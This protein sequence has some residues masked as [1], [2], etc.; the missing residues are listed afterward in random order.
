[1]MPQIS[2]ERLTMA[3][4]VI[5]REVAARLAR[6]P[7]QAATEQRLWWELSSCLLSSQVPYPLAVAAAD[8]IDGQGLLLAPGGGVETLASG[9]AA[10]LRGKLLVNGRPRAYRFAATRASQLAKTRFKVTEAAGG[11]SELLAGFSHPSEARAWLVRNAPGI[12]PKQA[13]MFLRNCGASYD[14]AIL[15]RHVMWYMSMVRLLPGPGRGIGSLSGYDLHEERL[16]SHA[17]EI[18]HAVGLLDWAIWIVVRAAR[19][20]DQRPRL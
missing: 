20:S 9:L 18:G 12:G 1:M 4:E 16:R 11:L 10:V 15:D 13:S 2:P 7:R 6:Q 14:L 3:V 19:A 8:V 5:G 17:R